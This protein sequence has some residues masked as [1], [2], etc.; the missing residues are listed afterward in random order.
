VS[1]EEHGRSSQKIAL[2]FRGIRLS[3]TVQDG[4]KSNDLLYSMWTLKLQSHQFSDLEWSPPSTR[5]HDL[6]IFY[7]FIA[8]GQDSTVVGLG[9]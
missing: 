1:F 4:H 5:M 3:M 9:L 8:Y 2:M 7:M 6:R